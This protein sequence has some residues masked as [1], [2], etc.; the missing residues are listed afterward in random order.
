MNQANPRYTL[1]CDNTINADRVEVFRDGVFLREFTLNNGRNEVYADET[2]DVF[3]V[4]VGAPLVTALS[5]RLLF[6]A[7][8]V[9]RKIWCYTDFQ[10]K[11]Q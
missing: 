7:L 11:P 8:V 2:G 1:V 9:D 4:G 5:A 3:F 6:E 10:R